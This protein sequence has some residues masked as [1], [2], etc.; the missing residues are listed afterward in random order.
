MKKMFAFFVTGTLAL[1]LCLPMLG[2]TEG[3]KAEAASGTGYTSAEDVVYVKNDNCIANWGVRDETCGFLST[4]AE[5][6]YTGSYAFDQ[7]SL[8]AGGSS[9]STAPSSALY[10][11]LQS[12]MESKHTY[13]TSY[14]ATRYKFCY[15][16]CVQS[17]YSNISSFYSGEVL[18]GTWD[19][20]KTW[21][22]EHTWPNSKGDLAG[23]GENDIMMLRP[24]SVSENSSRGNKAYGKSSGYYDPNGEGES[25][26]G[27]CAR[28]ILYQYVRWGC[29]NTGSSY[30]SQDIFGTNG[31]IESLNILLDWMEEDPVD[32]WEM[33][34]NDAVQSITGTR[35]VFV[36]YPEYAWLLF[37]RA[38]PKN[39]ST[40]SGEASDGETDTPS[41]E[42]ENNGGTTETPTEEEE[43]ECD[44]EYGK[45]YIIARPTLTEEGERTA[46]CQKCGKELTETIPMLTEEEDSTAD[47]SEVK[48]EG[49]AATL[50]FAS[51]G[52]LALSA[53]C[54]CVRKRRLRG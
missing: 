45:W 34:R 13:V 47:D 9:S 32:T 17:N 12:M 3:V 50:G 52:G 41:D 46:F 7:M 22:R 4:Y 20:G 39:M 36:D 18:S 51:L 8:N 28:I 40:P 2:R 6:F 37:G 24:A 38:L 14:D 48:K 49:C 53:V 21:N 19:G 31:V 27:D 42:D 11:S 15:T 54:L 5:N 29:I 33:G 25:V 23:N 1:G 35:N 43:S 10:K 30:N 44:H 26:R 16:D